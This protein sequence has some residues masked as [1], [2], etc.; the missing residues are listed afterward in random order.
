M[1]TVGL[2][3]PC[4]VLPPLRH[5]DR[6]EEH[7]DD[8]GREHQ[9]DLGYENENI[10][11]TVLEL[12]NSEK[13]PNSETKDPAVQIFEKENTLIEDG[14]SGQSKPEMEQKTIRH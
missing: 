9:G 13:E 5:Q 8:R 10:E 12:I 11:T 14:L 7:R 2:A 4:L 3:Q 1:M 6:E